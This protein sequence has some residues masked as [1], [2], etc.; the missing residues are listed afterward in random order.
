MLYMQIMIER[1]K[2][3][4]NRNSSYTNKFI[5]TRKKKLKKKVYGKDN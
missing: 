1:K 5:E 3:L 4:F 2:Y